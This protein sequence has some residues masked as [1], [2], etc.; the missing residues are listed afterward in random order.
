MTCYLP[1]RSIIR[2]MKKDNVLTKVVRKVLF[3][4]A[5]IEKVSS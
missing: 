2:A 5:Y 3:S 1:L 4:N